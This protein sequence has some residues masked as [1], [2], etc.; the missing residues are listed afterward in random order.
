MGEEEMKIAGYIRVSTPR[1]AKDGESLKTQEN[2]IK[3]F[4]K[5]KKGWKLIRIYSDKG[6]SGSKAENR[7]GFMQM[8]EDSNKGKFQA[9][10]FTSVS[11]FAR[12]AGQFLYFRDNLK[13]KGVLLFGI[14]EGIDP[15]IKAHK[16]MMDIFAVVADWERE[17]IRE[18]MAE[19]KIAKWSDKRAFIGQPPYGYEWDK[20]KKELIIVPKEKEIYN[21]VVDMYL[22]L[23]MSFHRIAIKL[24]EEGKKGKRAY[25]ASATISGMLKNPAYYG[26]YVV[27][28][29]K[30]GD[31]KRGVGTIR[32]NELKPA[33]EHIKFEIP[34]LISK[35]K[36]DK[37][38]E[39]TKVN[40]LKVGRPS[41]NY[42]D[43]WLS[44]IVKCG[45]C[46]ARVRPH[47]GNKRKDGTFPR[48]YSCHWASTS[49]TDLKVNNRKK[50]KLPY[51]KA[52][53]LEGSVWLD[54]IMPLHFDKE[55]LNPLTE[56]ARFKKEL[57]DINKH[58]SHLENELKN[59][60]RAES[61][62]DK[63]LEDEDF[64]MDK[65]KQMQIENQK[66]QLRIQAQLSDARLKLKKM[67]EIETNKE[68]LHDF[69]KDKHD[70]I[71]RMISDLRSLSP[72]DKKTFAESLIEGKVK[73]DLTFDDFDRKTHTHN[74]EKGFNFNLTIFEEFMRQGKIGENSKYSPDYTAGH[75]L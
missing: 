16:V 50:C 60:K 28:Q 7:P 63:T 24:R 74:Y 34:H 30:Y 46:G 9:I 69:K 51:I 12:N 27:N 35:T 19:N 31:S 22:D 54:L 58:I 10:V 45:V 40:T 44:D 72:E 8:M 11:R 55:D 68:Q 13:E 33:S 47:N 66:E 36:W 56:P 57:E 15:T 25:F 3:H 42:K 29:F 4:I 5:G 14:K 70:I 64:N 71:N 23:G 32:T 20:E 41:P 65:Y 52:D 21:S 67:E 43:Y 26:H 75:D 37:L 6:I 1:Q 53:D 49:L 17:A 39:K 18:Q 2:D 62:I 59:K 48:Y 73:V 38:Q 61:R